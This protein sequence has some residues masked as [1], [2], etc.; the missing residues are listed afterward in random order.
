[1]GIGLNNQFMLIDGW[2][3]GI[4]GGKSGDSDER[5]CKNSVTQEW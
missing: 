2:R 3:L 1:M 4:Y 5:Y